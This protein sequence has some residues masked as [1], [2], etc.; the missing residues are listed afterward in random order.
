MPGP[1]IERKDIT[2]TGNVTVSV[3]PLGF[4]ASHNIQFV[5]EIFHTPA[6]GI[7][8]GT[9]LGF[10]GMISIGLTAFLLYNN[11]EQAI[12]KGATIVFLWFMLFGGFL[13]STALIFVPL[14]PEF[15][16]CRSG[17]VFFLF[18]VFFLL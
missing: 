9:G 12:M 6:W 15:V 8:I 4:K 3:S 1:S 10:F 2:V 11:R 17:F 18:F 13:L 5:N 14:I 7:L 16:D